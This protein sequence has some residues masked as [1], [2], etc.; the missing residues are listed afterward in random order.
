MRRTSI[1]DK[2]KE[3]AGRMLF[4]LLSLNVSFVQTHAQ[5]YRPTCDTIYF[6]CFNCQ[7]PDTVEINDSTFAI[8]YFEV[9]DSAGVYSEYYYDNGNRVVG[10][11]PETKLQLTFINKGKPTEYLLHK[12]EL[13][14]IIDGATLK[15]M[16]FSSCHYLETTGNSCYFNCLM[17]V[18]ETDIC[19][20]IIVSIDILTREINCQIYEEDYEVTDD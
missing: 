5:E 3:V 11:Y 6:D 20:S 7:H 9:L 14:K 8:Y 12:K 13:E 4:L 2:I 17:C 15:N 18:P 19:A 1:V 16:I 10:C